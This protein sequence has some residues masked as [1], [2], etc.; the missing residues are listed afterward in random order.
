MQSLLRRIQQQHGIRYNIEN[1]ERDLEEI[2]K[3]TSQRFKRI[4]LL[5]TIHK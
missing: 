3:S 5:N 2:N 1:L 4:N